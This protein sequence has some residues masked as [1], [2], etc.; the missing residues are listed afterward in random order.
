MRDHRFEHVDGAIGPLR[1]EIASLPRPGI[2][3]AVAA[4]GNR[5]RRQPCQ[6]GQIHPLEPFV[7]GQIEPIRRQ[8]L[9]DRA[10]AGMAHRLMP[11]LVIVR[12]LPEALAR[13]VLALRLDRHRRVAE[14]IEQRIHSFT[15]QR[16][17]M[18]HA[19]MTAALADGLVER[20][21][22]L[23]RAE[24]RDI[25]HPKPADGF[26][27]ELKFRDRNEVKRAHVEQRALGLGVETTDRFERVAEEIEPH[28][29]IEAC[30]K[31]I[32]NAA[33]NRVFAG[34][35]HRG[36]A[37]VAIMLQ[38]R[39]DGV[40]RH[41]MAGC[42][43]QRLRRNYFARRHPLHDGVDRGQHDQ[44][45]VAARQSRQPCQRGQPLCQDAAMRRYP[46]VGLAVP[47]RKLHDRQIGGEEF[48][49]P[50]Q[51]LHARRIAANHRKA[52]RRRLRSRRDRAREVRH[53]EPLGTLG[54]IGKG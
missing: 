21:V 29:L 45:L 34:L 20:I 17:P 1:R 24:C 39:H 23:G 44:R 26:G 5:K 3:H 33:A 10:A 38:P 41:H 43:R 8:R 51:L 31:Q 2:D 6:R 16:Q 15:E 50:R 42:H 36:G 18:L 47:G 25:A 30:R 53:H 19:G 14:I 11:R 12:D 37:A 4:L 22:A 48:Q 9:V 7:L 27:G 54:H 35:A 28:G 46:V 52:D 13:G 40:H 32:E 49:R